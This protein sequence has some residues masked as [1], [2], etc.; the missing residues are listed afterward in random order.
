MPG[1]SGHSTRM[2]RSRAVPS[3]NS[4]P[5]RL[6]GV[7][8]LRNTSLPSGSPC[9]ATP[10]RRPSGR[11]TTSSAIGADYG[12][13]VRVARASVESRQDPR[14][15]R[16]AVEP[17][18]VLAAEGPQ[19][20]GGDVAPVLLDH[21][22]GVGP[23]TVTVG[24]VDLGHHVVD[25]DAVAGVD[26][27]GVVDRAEPEVSLQDLRR[28]QIP[29]EAV[30]R[31]VDDVVEPVEKHRHPPDATLRHGDLELGIAHRPARPQPL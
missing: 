17:G 27:G 16:V 20:G 28:P 8:W 26:R 9:E 31:T 24:I 10:T 7:P 18:G 21:E 25:T 19:L 5:R 14:R 4:K 30:A 22:L 29:P 1:R 11:R 6:A 12:D 3:V 2:P 15:E 13:G 23:G